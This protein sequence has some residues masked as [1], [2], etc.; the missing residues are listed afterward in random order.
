VSDVQGEAFGEVVPAPGV[1]DE[2]LDSSIA[3]DGGDKRPSSAHVDKACGTVTNAEIAE[4]LGGLDENV[5]AFTDRA[6]FY[7]NLVRKLQ[8][9]VESLQVDQVQQLLG[10]VLTRLAIL[11]TQSADSAQLARIHGEGYRADVE[12]EYF[13][14]ALIETLDLIGVESVG[15][16][17]GAAF[18]RSVHAS[19]KT[20]RTGDQALDWTVAKVLRQGLVRPGSER[21]FLPAQV[22]VYRYDAN[23]DRSADEPHTNQES[24]QEGTLA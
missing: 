14:D 12:F 15:A 2:V 17:P 3:S 18:D 8:N 10:P 11:V 20:V 21:A 7:E 23:L 4:L 16:T 24:D 22:S 6:E 9:R 1:A 5:R 13:H 19:R